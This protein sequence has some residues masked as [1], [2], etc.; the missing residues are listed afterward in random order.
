MVSAGAM[1]LMP[2]LL[3]STS[4]RPQRESMAV[5]NS[6][7]AFSLAISAAK[8]SAPAFRLFNAA[9]VSDGSRRSISAKA[10]PRSARISAVRR[11]MPCAAPVT[12]AT[13]IGGWLLRDF[14]ARFLIVTGSDGRDA[15]RRE[16]KQDAS[17]WPQILQNAPFVPFRLKEVL[18]QNR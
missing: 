4:T 9:N 18:Y 6:L 3:T 12:T 15:W 8:L 16:R 13:F 11:P 14:I 7:M 17:L 5:A 2:A 10:N 1:K